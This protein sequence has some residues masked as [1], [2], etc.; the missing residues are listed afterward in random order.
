MSDFTLQYNDDDRAS[1]IG[2]GDPNSFTTIPDPT[3]V[4][5]GSPSGFCKEGVFFNTLPDTRNP[6][7]STTWVWTNGNPAAPWVARP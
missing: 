4:V 1:F 2:S 6:V 7:A 3:T 5:S